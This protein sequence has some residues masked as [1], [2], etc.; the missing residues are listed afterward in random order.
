M[1]KY[2]APRGLGWPS[3]SYTLVFAL[4]A[5][6]PAAGIAAESASLHARNLAGLAG[7]LL[8]KG[9]QA[10][11]YLGGKFEGEGKY[12]SG[13]VEGASPAEIELADFPIVGRLRGMDEVHVVCS[14]APNDPALNLIQQLNVHAT[15]VLSVSGTITGADRGDSEGK[16]VA[17]V[18]LR[19]CIVEKKSP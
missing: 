4:M 8:A 12:R 13:P 14:Y 15:P 2:V 1:M 5:T 18:K 3:L 17:F 7:A 16:I 10:K 9:P 11:K 6:A 19:D